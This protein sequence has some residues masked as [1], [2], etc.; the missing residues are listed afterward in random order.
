[1]S[2]YLLLV[3]S[4]PAPGQE[5]AYHEWYDGT[6]LADVIAVAGFKAASRYRPVPAVEGVV[7]TDEY[8]A[9]YE[10]ESDDPAVTMAE[11]MEAASNMYIPPAIDL[12]TVR[13]E[14]QKLITPRLERS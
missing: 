12:S 6:H 13:L 9:I 4:K 7:P 1:M 10:I 8:L 5:A 2:K 3:F 14:L 11:L